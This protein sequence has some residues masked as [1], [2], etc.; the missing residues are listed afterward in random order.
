MKTEKEIA[1]EYLNEFLPTDNK[2]N[3]II[4]AIELIEWNIDYSCFK[5]N[6]N[7]TLE[8][9]IKILEE[10]SIT[11][12]KLSRGLTSSFFPLEEETMNKVYLSFLQWFIEEIVEPIKTSSN[13]DSKVFFQKIYQMMKEFINRIKQTQGVYDENGFDFSTSNVYG[14]LKQ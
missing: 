12:L 3:F 2:R 10:I 7:L 11:F 1:I 9:K 4:G 5:H 14:M 13:L 8:G 6:I